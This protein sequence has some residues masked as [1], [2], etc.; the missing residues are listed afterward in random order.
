MAVGRTPAFQ[1]AVE[2][3]LDMFR[4]ARESWKRMDTANAS[5]L[6]KRGVG[7]FHLTPYSK[8]PIETWFVKVNTSFFSRG[9]TSYPKKV[10]I[11]SGVRGMSKPVGC[12]GNLCNCYWKEYGLFLLLVLKGLDFTG[13]VFCRVQDLRVGAKSRRPGTLPSSCTSWTRASGPSTAPRKKTGDLD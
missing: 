6:L 13:N 11:R 9:S 1:Q 4:E 8:Y 7:F 5:L 12:K 10:D 2:A 3:W